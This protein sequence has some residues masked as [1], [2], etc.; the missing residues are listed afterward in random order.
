VTSKYLAKEYLIIGVTDN[1]Y[2]SYNN[3]KKDTFELG[4]EEVKLSKETLNRS[5]IAI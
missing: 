2:A 3:P 5:D 1:A 4:E